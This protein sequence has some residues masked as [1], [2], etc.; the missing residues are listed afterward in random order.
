MSPLARLETNVV[1]PTAGSHPR[2]TNCARWVGASARHDPSP[3]RHEGVPPLARLGNV[4]HAFG[5]AEA[6]P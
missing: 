4:I 3:S 5:T 2:L 6:V 1:T